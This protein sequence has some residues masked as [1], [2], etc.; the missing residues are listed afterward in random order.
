MA[1]QNGR[2]LTIKRGSVEVKIFRTEGAY[3]V[4]WY[5]GS[6]RVRKRRV[7]LDQAKLLAEEVASRIHNGQ[8]GAELLTGDDRMAYLNALET[9]AP[10]GVPL[11][12]AA[13]SFASAL[14]QLGDRGTLQDA[15]KFFLAHSQDQLVH[16]SLREAYEEYLAEKQDRTSKRNVEAIRLHV[17][18][19]AD[20][21]KRLDLIEVTSRQIDTYLRDVRKHQG[22]TFN[23]ARAQIVSFFIW[24]R[25]NHYLGD[26]ETEAEKVPKATEKKEAV[27][28]FSPQEFASIL[29]HVRQDLIPYLTLSAFAGLRP[30]E[31]G[32]LE[33]PQ[34]HWD[35]D[36]IEIVASVAQKTLRNRFVPLLP[37][38]KTWLAEGLVARWKAPRFLLSDEVIRLQEAGVMSG[39]WPPDVLRHSFGSYRLAI[40]Q[41]RNCLAD[42]MGNSVQVIVRNYRRPVSKPRGE[43]WF[44]IVPTV[45]DLT[46][47]NT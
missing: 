27:T 13:S 33:W 6:M 31:A 17:G 20:Y 37:N 16:R 8:A 36:Y 7:R 12:E 35:D 28:I 38:L 1:V 11:T 23:N 42:E 14:Q 32:R 24:A 18:K 29:R 19:L 46:D 5:E 10:T 45:V 2:P 22:R 34:I 30:S 21:Y 9:L 44:A 3:T 26:F 15:V 39:P 41:D 4:S 43:S 47:P 25:K 40:T